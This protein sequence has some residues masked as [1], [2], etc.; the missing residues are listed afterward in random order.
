MTE[1][2]A[3]RM[4]RLGVSNEEIKALHTLWDT[5]AIWP[6]L[7]ETAL[8]MQLLGFNPL[9]SLDVASHQLHHADAA[10]YLRKGFTPHQAFLLI[11]NER[12]R[13]NLFGDDSGL[14][15]HDNL[16]DTPMPPEMLTELLVVADSQTEAEQFIVNIVGTPG[17]PAQARDN[18]DEPDAAT[19][20]DLMTIAARAARINVR[21][22]VCNCTR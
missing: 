20:E 5:P 6:L 14:D 8:G 10:T 7:S 9:D 16:I 4:D 11:N 22:D 12:A 18:D 1:T 21:T 2:N 13:G 17:H 19:V 15:K 3:D